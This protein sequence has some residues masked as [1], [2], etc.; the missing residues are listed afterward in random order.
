M[1]N[2]L[3]AA[4]SFV[5]IP[6]LHGQ[7]IDAQPSQP[8]L[9]VQNGKY[10]YIDHQGKIVV[11]PQF[12]W[13]TQFS[14]GLA[15]VYVCGRL[16]SIDPSGKILPLRLALDGELTLR[17]KN[18]KVG[19]I[20]ASGEFKIP[21]TFDQALPFSEG[22]AA[23]AVGNK[24][25]FIGTGGEFVIEPKFDAAFYFG[26]GVGMVESKGDLELVNRAGDVVA[27]GLGPG[28]F[29]AEGRVLAVRAGKYGY[30]DLRGNIAVPFVYDSGDYFSG[31]LAAVHKG[32]RFG[33]INRAGKLVLPF[34]FDSAG[35]FLGPGLAAV[36]KKDLTGFI[37][38]S[39]RLAIG[40]PFE[41]ASGFMY[42]D[43]SA[44]WTNDYHFGY[45]TAAGKVI[46]GPEA[47]SPDHQPLFG[48]SEKDKVE[49][50]RGIPDSLRNEV[51][52]F[53]QTGE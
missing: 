46:W 53:P 39:G 31:G 30:L 50:C 7:R 14:N 18:G 5:V 13:G 33:Y 40:L 37:D 51:Y 12:A 32:D 29:V 17:S 47:G 24:W 19:F 20:D 1:S 41:H 6:T 27:R 52:S 4:L 11:R 43:V 49:S 8:L 25:G 38:R 35:P 42:G 34:E 26:E 10:G 3:V 22:L 28:A 36:R 45:V 9:I 48:W 16:V 23:V 2:R 15:T 44:F 21:P